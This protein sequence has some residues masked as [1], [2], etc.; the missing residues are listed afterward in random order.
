MEDPRWGEH[1][2]G[3]AYWGGGI[4][5]GVGMGVADR[6]GGGVA[7]GDVRR[8]LISTADTVIL[9]KRRHSFFPLVLKE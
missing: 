5:G 1:G 9:D 8:K 3:V 7:S 2:G 6:G 4:R